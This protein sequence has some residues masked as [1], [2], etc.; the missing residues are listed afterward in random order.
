MHILT[1]EDFEDYEEEDEPIFCP[2][3][4]NRGYQNRIG[5]KILMPGEPKP[6]NY[7]DYWE[8][9][10]C[11]LNGDITQL[12]KEATVKNAVETVESPQDDKLK[13]ATAH[14]R[15]KPT[16]KVSRHINKH[17]R[18]T[19]DPDIALAIKQVG[20]DNVKVLMDTNP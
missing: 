6:E 15:R 5:P 17:I 10:V 1:A 2:T 4:L 9:A 3:C 7:E 20:E 16:R 12:A 18:K 14:K 11:G 19:K 8:C 13:L